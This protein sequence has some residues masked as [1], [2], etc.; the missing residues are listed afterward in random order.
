[1]QQNI[2]TGKWRPIDLTKEPFNL[3]QPIEIINEDLDII[4]DLIL[5]AFNDAF[6][7]IN[8]ELDSKMKKVTGGVGSF[9]GLI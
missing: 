8:K 4:E 2:N 1:M 5:I 6:K 3:P 7:K 9:P